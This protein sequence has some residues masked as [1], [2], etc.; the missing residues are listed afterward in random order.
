VPSRI[1]NPVFD[2]L[3]E[4]ALPAVLDGTHQRD[5]PPIDGGRWPVTVVARPPL[6]ARAVLEALMRE[7]LAHAG[8][9]HFVTG[10]QDSVH[11]TIRALEPYREA[12]AASDDIVGRWCDPIDRAARLTPP[13]R[14]TVTGVT[15]SRVGVMAQVEP[16]D[17]EPWRFMDRL[18]AELGELAWF[19][20]QWMR[21][22]I[23]YATLIHFA[24]DV[25][26]P[27]GLIEWLHNHRTINRVDFAITAVELVRS[28]H[29]PMDPADP[30]SE[31]LMRPET[32]FTVPLSG[33]TD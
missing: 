20:D 2:V 1:R 19:E 28:R 5:G 21:R 31:Q 32:W 14:L 25:A 26:D 18:A 4:A 16:A 10:R 27:R 33:D 11:L 13:L 12:A 15:L 23:W 7:A 3:L 17:D 6:E 24:D 9:G 8:R 22:N 29:A 30:T